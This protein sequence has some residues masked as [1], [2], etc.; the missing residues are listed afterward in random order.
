M[1]VIGPMSRRKT[2]PD[3]DQQDQP[4]P[5]QVVQERLARE[6]EQLRQQLR[7]YK[8]ALRCA[9]KTLRPYDER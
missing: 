2:P 1:A 6:N 9:A 7:T 5:E 8:A 4:S 3:D